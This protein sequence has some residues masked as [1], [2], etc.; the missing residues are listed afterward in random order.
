MASCCGYTG[1]TWCEPSACRRPDGLSLLFL[2]SGIIVCTIPISPALWPSARFRRA[3]AAP[4]GAHSAEDEALRAGLVPTAPID[5]HRLQPPAPVPVAVSV[6]HG[7][8]VASICVGCHGQHL[9]GGRIPG[10]PPEWPPAANLTP[11]SGSAMLGY[12]TP[13]KFAAM[14]RSGKRPD[15][16]AVSEVMPFTTVAKMND[17]GLAA[18]HAYLRTLPPRAAGGR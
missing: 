17:T 18:M 16:T 8:Y 13:E 4:R 2:P 7:A 5:R 14:M 15:G 12:D 10:T 1:E 11:G 6:E 9:S 3:T